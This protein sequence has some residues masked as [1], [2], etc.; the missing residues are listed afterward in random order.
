MTSGYGFFQNYQPEI[1]TQ[2]SALLTKEI[3]I[4]SVT[5]IMM[6]LFVV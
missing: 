6:Q 2:P 4:I 1:N 3:M 5:G